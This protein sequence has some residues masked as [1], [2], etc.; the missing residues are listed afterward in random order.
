MNTVSEVLTEFDLKFLLCIWY[1]EVNETWT[2]NTEYINNILLLGDLSK[3]KNPD[4]I[5]EIFAFKKCA[6]V[7]EKKAGGEVKYNLGPNT[8]TS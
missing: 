3:T 1:T 5:S 4:L 6:M 8:Y 2:P 7:Q